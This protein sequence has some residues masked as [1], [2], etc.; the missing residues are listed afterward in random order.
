VIF[1]RYDGDW[2]SPTISPCPTWL[3]SVA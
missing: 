2:P 3:I 1:K